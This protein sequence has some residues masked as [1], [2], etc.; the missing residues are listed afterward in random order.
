MAMPTG[1]LFSVLFWQLLSFG[2]TASCVSLRPIA[3]H[4]TRLIGTASARFAITSS[5]GATPDPAT[6]RSCALG[7]RSFTQ[8]SSPPPVEYATVISGR[9]R[10]S[11]LVAWANFG[12]DLRPNMHTLVL[13]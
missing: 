10:S 7:K 8:P 9:L 5:T 3:T 12:F 4:G 6:P 13:E 1:A 11:T 2:N